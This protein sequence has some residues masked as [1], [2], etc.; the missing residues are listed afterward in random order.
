MRNMARSAGHTRGLAEADY[1]SV[2]FIYEEIATFEQTPED[3]AESLRIDAIERQEP[4]DEVVSVDGEQWLLI[5][6]A[7]D[8]QHGRS[9]CSAVGQ[10]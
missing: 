9:F 8:P 3:A 6:G 4:L 5:C 10:A 2:D 7:S 1:R